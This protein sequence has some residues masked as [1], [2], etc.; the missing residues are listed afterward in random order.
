MKAYVEEKQNQ[1]LNEN[2][3]NIY[4]QK[5]SLKDIDSGKKNDRNDDNDQFF[6]NLSID[7]LNICKKCH[8]KR[9]ILKSNNAFH[10][11]IRDCT[12][13]E[14][15]I[16]TTLKQHNNWSLIKSRAKNTVHKEY[17]FRSY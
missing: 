7:T 8:K 14:A 6:Y 11:H 2:E 12:D 9:E 16:N 17:D 5:K 3:E 15:K 4:E 13:D 10:T 1:R